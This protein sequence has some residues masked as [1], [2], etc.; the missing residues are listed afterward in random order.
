MALL[1][2]LDKVEEVSILWT[3]LSNTASCC[4]ISSLSGMNREETAELSTLNQA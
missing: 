3:F 4:G 2:L 1:T